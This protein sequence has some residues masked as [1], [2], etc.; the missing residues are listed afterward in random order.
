M[1]CTD[2][3][4]PDPADWCCSTCDQVVTVIEAP[5]C[6]IDGPDEVCEDAE[7]VLYSTSEDADSYEWTITG[8]GEIVGTPPHNG[9]SVLVNPTGEVGYILSLEVC[10]VN[11][12]ECCT[13]CYLEVDIIPTPDCTILGP[14]TICEEDIDTPVEYC[15]DVVASNKYDWNI[16]SGL[17]TIS[18]AD[19]EMCVDIIPSALGTIVLELI[20]CDDVLPTQ[21][22]PGECCNSCE[23]EILV[24]ECGG[25]YC[26]FTQG[27]YGNAGGTQCGDMTTTAIINAALLSGP[28]IIGD[29]DDGP[30]ITLNSAA[31]IIERLPAGGKPSALPSGIGEF[32]DDC[33]SSSS[34]ALKKL[35]L[36]KKKN[37][38]GERYQNVLIGQVVALTLN[39]RL[40]TIPCMDADGFDQG[41]GEYEFPD[42]D[43]IC[44]QKGEEGCIERYE[45]P[46]IL[47]GMPVSVLLELANEALAGDK[48]LIGGAYAGA[49]FVNE[50]FDECWTIVTCPPEDSCDYC[51]AD[52]DTCVDY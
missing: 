35:G 52:T 17:A 30:S 4:A 6:S 34:A 20:V 24:E 3:G 21:G 43:Y 13:T 10:S 47:K 8:D 5:D 16:V 44:V 28:V 40:H 14:E 45:I 26:T 38:Q 36:L 42:A 15:T 29:P 48:A 25:G 33:G 1:V 31:C 49:S 32:V 12:Y 50:L 46:E 51:D 11:G 9:T 2:N 27:Y 22:D 23:I 7:D 39:M 37:K 41:L 18:G 19:D